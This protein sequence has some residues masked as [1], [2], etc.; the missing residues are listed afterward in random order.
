[1]GGEH[2]IYGGGREIHAGFL[3]RKDNIKVGLQ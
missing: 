2:C 1:M 3:W